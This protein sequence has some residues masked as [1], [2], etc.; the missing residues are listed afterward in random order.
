MTTKELYDTIIS[1]PDLHSLPKI[2]DQSLIWHLYKTAYVR[3]CCDGADSFI[4][5]FGGDG[6]T[7]SLMRQRL[8]ENEMVNALYALSKKGNM[9][10]LKKSLLGTNI[11]YCRGVVPFLRFSLF[12]FDKN[13]NST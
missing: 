2:Y 6:F 4:E 10:V 11:F 12:E 5:I 1:K 9:L 8:D 13:A 3:A 7:G